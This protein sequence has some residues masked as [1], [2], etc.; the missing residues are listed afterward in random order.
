MTELIVCP[1]C[2]GAGTIPVYP[3][4]E[5]EAKH[6]I[7]KIGDKINENIE[8]FAYLFEDKP[9]LKKLPYRTC[10]VCRGLGMIR[11]PD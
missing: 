7:D 8:K 10:P 4:E 3:P 9:H 6:I 11:K 5:K 2:N 1:K